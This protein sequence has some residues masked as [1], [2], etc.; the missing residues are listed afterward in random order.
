MLDVELNHQIIRL[1]FVEGLSIRKIAQQLQVHRKTVRSRI[2]QYNQFKSATETNKDDSSAQLVQYLTK[3]SVYN[4]SGREARKLTPEV[5]RHID[6]LLEENERRR[7]D[8]RRK[9][10]LRKID[11]HELVASSGHDLSY[12]SVCKYIS[13][14]T[15]RAQEAYIKQDYPLG[16]VCEFDWGEVRLNIAG[17]SRRFYMAVFTS[18]YSNYRFAIL[19]ERQHSLAFREAHILFFGHV[20]GVWRQMTYDNM[21][22][23]IA[24]FV[25]KTEKR[26]TEA[27]KQL[28]GWYLFDWRF[29]NIKRGNEKGHVERSIEYIRRKCFA[30]KDDFETFEQAQQYLASRLSELNKRKPQGSKLSPYDKLEQEKAYLLAHP[31]QMACFDGNHSKVDKFATISLA[32]NRYSVPDRLTGSL[33]FVK[34]YSSHIEISDEN[35]LVCTHT[36]S[37]E[38]GGWYINLDHYLVTLSRKPGA[39]HGSVALKQAPEWIR[40]LYERHFAHTPRC[41]VELLQYCKTHEITHGRLKDTV[42]M[43]MRRHTGAIS[44]DHIL[45]LLGNQPDISCQT[46]ELNIPGSIATQAMEN[47]TE[48]ASMMTN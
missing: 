27:L 4:S 5:A 40:Q 33:V 2:D 11:I 19:F 47:L 22:V 45:A 21:R 13:W 26:P 37:Y 7:L 46:P 38:R 23:A 35:G 24:E 1:H 14:K 42:E 28:A 41:F 34:K 17:K 44:L 31:G 29:C 20:A 36:R 9:Q 10:Q 6:E 3:G 16:G 15:K 32:T 18:A 12:S 39:V 25:G 43:L 8:G 30:F 48:L